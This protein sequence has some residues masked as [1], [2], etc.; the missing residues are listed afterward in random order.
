MN[1]TVVVLCCF[2]VL[3]DVCSGGGVGCLSGDCACLV[4]ITAERNIWHYTIHDDWKQYTPFQILQITNSNL[5]GG[6]DVNTFSFYSLV[7][8]QQEDSFIVA[9]QSNASSPI[10]QSSLFG[11]K[12]EYS[13]NYWKGVS[14]YPSSAKLS[15]INYFGFPISIAALGYQGDTLKAT[16][17]TTLLVTLIQTIGC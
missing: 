12:A 9:A 4:G 15:P 7:Y 13:N 11:F 17:V 14:P 16:T 6:V 3:V 8:N 2:V 10:P 5:E 1:W